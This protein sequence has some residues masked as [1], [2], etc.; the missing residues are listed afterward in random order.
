[1]STYFSYQQ[2]KNASSKE[3]KL[4]EWAKLKDDFLPVQFGFLEKILVDTNTLFL[5]GEKPNAADVTFFAVFGVYKHAG[6]GADEVLM[7][8]P[9]LKGAYEAAKTLGRLADF[10]PEGHFFTAD[11]EHSMF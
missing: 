10:K 6:M 11:P 3:A 8:F 7:Q 5:G 9:K 1:L 4:E 2:A